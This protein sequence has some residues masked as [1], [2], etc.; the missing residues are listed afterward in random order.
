MLPP[1]PVA[2]RSSCFQAQELLTQ[3]TQKRLPPMEPVP[4]ALWFNYFVSVK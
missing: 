3:L 1:C 2:A 4:K